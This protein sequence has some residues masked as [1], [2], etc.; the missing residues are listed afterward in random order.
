MPPEAAW[1]LESLRAD[2]ELQQRFDELA[3]KNTEGAITDD[4]LAEYDDLLRTS[5]LL[6]VLQMRARMVNRLPHIG[7]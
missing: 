4:E 6:A 1:W 2:N 7:R 5:E 3:S